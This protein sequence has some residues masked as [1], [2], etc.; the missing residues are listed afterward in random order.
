MELWRPKVSWTLDC[1]RSLAGGVSRW[2]TQIRVRQRRRKPGGTAWRRPSGG[3]KRRRRACSS[4]LVSR[5][6]AGAAD[7][8]F[9][10]YLSLLSLWDLA[11]TGLRVR[12]TTAGHLR[13]H[14]SDRLPD[15]DVAAI[16]LPRDKMRAIIAHSEAGRRRHA[17]TCPRS[18]LR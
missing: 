18:P 10:L 7:L 4:S 17:T 16:N 5:Y 9:D 11:G 15:E 2:G 12:R 13:I 6:F 8:A 3:R 14:P 1:E